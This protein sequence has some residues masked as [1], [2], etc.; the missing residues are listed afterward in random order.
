[1]QANYIQEM[2]DAAYEIIKRNELSELWKDREH[3]INVA[4]NTKDINI[5]NDIFDTFVKYEE[6]VD[7]GIY[8]AISDNAYIDKHLEQEINGCHAKLAQPTLIELDD[9]EIHQV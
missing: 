3:V 6:T 1:M 9:M 2:T 4:K 5:L 7:I 8:H